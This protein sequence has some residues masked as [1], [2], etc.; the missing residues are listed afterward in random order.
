MHVHPPKILDV[1]LNFEGPGF[2]LSRRVARK[3]IWN[4]CAFHL[5]Y[6]CVQNTFNLDKIA[7][8]AKE[9]VLY[10]PFFFNQTFS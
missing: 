9:S 2:F 3:W 8:D 10:C 4:I 5:F 7:C 6:I 1:V